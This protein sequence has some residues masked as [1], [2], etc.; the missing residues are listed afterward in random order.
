M[1]QKKILVVDDDS[2]MRLALQQRL[3]AN[4]Y[5][6]VSAGGWRG[7]YLRSAKAHAGPDDPGSWFAGWGRGL[8]C[9]ND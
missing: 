7:E 4:N 9:W 6:V 2:D 5:E 1:S 3:T 8:V